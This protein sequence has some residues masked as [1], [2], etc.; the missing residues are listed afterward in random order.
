VTGREI[1]LYLA[2]GLIVVASGIR[3]AWLRRETKIENPSP[4]PPV[5]GGDERGDQRE[6]PSRA[7]RPRGGVDHRPPPPAPVE[8]DRRL[9]RDHADGDCP[10]DPDGCQICR[11]KAPERV[12]ED[13]VYTVLVPAPA[14]PEEC[15]YDDEEEDFDDDPESRSGFR[16]W[17]RTFGHDIVY[18]GPN[19][20]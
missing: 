5:D 10:L 11:G 15:D 9:V 2:I 18:G 7:R 17:L 6:R 1:A 20:R 19:R 4:P 14:G 13:K 8:M 16:G 3:E 12:V